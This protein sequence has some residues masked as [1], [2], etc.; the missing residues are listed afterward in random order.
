[1]AATKGQALDQLIDS[2]SRAGVSQ[3]RCLHQLSG[4][5]SQWL[6]L[7]IQVSSSIMKGLKTG[8]CPLMS[9]ERRCY[10]KA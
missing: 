1:M 4:I 9:R 6:D 8:H 10:E 2:S 5:F 3:F 7:G